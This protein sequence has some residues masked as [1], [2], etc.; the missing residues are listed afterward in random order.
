[1]VTVP[2]NAI[3]DCLPDCVQY[4]RLTDRLMFTICGIK[5]GFGG[6]EGNN[7]L[8]VPDYRL[9]SAGS[10]GETSLAGLG[11]THFTSKEMLL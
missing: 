4:P 2:I 3:T 1:M 11:P 10:R 9:P 7:H 6:L 8:Q 5:F